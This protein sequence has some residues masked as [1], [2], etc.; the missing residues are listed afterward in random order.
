MERS[1]EDWSEKMRKI[2]YFYGKWKNMME[3]LVGQNMD[4]K[5]DLTKM[6]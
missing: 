5:Q 6:R 2:V 4:E 1:S 3:E